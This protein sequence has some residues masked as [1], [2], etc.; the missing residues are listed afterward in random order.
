MRAFSLIQL[1]VCEGA[2]SLE[3]FSRTSSD[4]V[5][6]HVPLVRTGPPTRSIMAQNS[7]PQPVSVNY[8]EIPPPATQV[9]EQA[10]SSSQTEPPATDLTRRAIQAAEELA[11]ALKRFHPPT[12][13]KGTFLFFPPHL[14]ISL[15]THL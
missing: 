5:T 7:Q 12:L 4:C 11:K 8:T 2:S 10:G 14:Q 9:T 1:A 6:Y 13:G 3:F 15:P